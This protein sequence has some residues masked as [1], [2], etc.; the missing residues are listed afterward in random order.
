MEYELNSNAPELKQQRMNVIKKLGDSRTVL[1]GFGIVDLL[2]NF[3]R[4]L[5]T[6]KAQR[7]ASLVTNTAIKSAQYAMVHMARPEDSKFFKL[8]GMRRNP[9]IPTISL[10]YDWDGVRINSQAYL[11]APEFSDGSMFLNRWNYL[12]EILARV[13]IRESVP[14]RTNDTRLWQRT[15]EEYTRF[16]IDNHLGF[17]PEQKKGLAYQRTFRRT[18]G[19]NLIAAQ[20][21]VSGGVRV[22]DANQ[23]KEELLIGGV[24]DEYLNPSD[25]VLQSETRE[26]TIASLVKERSGEVLN[27]EYQNVTTIR[28]QAVCLDAAGNPVEN[29]DAREAGINAFQDSRIC[30]KCP[31][32]SICGNVVINQAMS[33]QGN[34][35]YPQGTERQIVPMLD[36]F[37]TELQD[38]V[39]R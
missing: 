8:F 13:S 4:N 22:V 31:L 3:Y 35:I 32:F 14:K 10:N 37:A 11:K 36:N 34:G 23:K 29:F 7:G 12:M 16:L 25:V 9:F 2:N 17:Y 33:A 38:R 6:I 21:E 15:N 1:H 5:N 24:L 28:T 30:W 39:V 27:P 20:V 18:V 26:A 19:L